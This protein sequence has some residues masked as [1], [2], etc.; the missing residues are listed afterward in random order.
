MFFICSFDAFALF[1]QGITTAA[2][3]PVNN[4]P[5]PF[6]SSVEGYIQIE[7]SA[8]LPSRAI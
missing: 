5:C 3:K 6:N 1:C 7:T 4:L 2:Q 8:E